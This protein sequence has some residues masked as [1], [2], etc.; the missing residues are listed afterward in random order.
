MGHPL[1]EVRFSVVTIQTC[2]VPLLQSRKT[3]DLACIKVRI[4]GEEQGLRCILI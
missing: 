1:R 2:P 3:L 4:V